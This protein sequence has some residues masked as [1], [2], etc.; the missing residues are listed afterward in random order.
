MGL[1]DPITFGEYCRG[2]KIRSRTIEKCSNFKNKKPYEFYNLN[3]IGVCREG[4]ETKYCPRLGVYCPKWD[5]VNGLNLVPDII[6]N[7]DNY[8]LKILKVNNVLMGNYAI[9]ITNNEE[10]ELDKKT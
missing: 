4:Q 2:F 10:Y 3:W 8:S 6:C 5:D 1:G 7:I 9:E